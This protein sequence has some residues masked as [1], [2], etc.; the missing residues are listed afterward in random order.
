[1][2]LFEPPALEAIYQATNSLPQK[3][4]LLAHLSLNIA[5]TEQVQ[6]TDSN[7]TILIGRKSDDI[8]KT[9]TLIGLEV[10]TSH[11]LRSFCRRQKGYFV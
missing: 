6:I 1:M 10:P 4:N 8:K 3:V 5:A 9:T 7:R 11:K 2:D